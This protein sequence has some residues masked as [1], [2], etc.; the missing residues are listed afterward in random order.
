MKRTVNAPDNPKPNWG[1]VIKIIIA[2]AS[3]IAG[4]LGYASMHP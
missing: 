3:A 1:L 2:L 4:A